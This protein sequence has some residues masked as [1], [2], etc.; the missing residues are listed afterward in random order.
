MY[1]AK[2]LIALSIGI[3][4]V[5]GTA[6]EAGEVIKVESIPAY[7]PKYFPFESGEK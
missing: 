7:R 2:I 4:L 1:F 3:C 6:L 5:I